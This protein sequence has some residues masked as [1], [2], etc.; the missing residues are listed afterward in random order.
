MVKSSINNCKRK[1]PDKNIDRIIK[2]SNLS[3]RYNIISGDC[4]SVAKAI[5]DV[6][7]GK[8]M[9]ISS[10]PE[11]RFFDHVVVNV[12]E[13]I[14]DGRGKISW[15]TVEDEFVPKNSWTTYNKHWFEVND[16]TKD[17]MYSEKITNEIVGIILN[18]IE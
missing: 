1:Y 10:V 13:Y 14:Y 4:S 7:G 8:I 3:N 9:S 6:F 16:I 5:Y 11:E 17:S 15:S 2:N 18:N 12:N